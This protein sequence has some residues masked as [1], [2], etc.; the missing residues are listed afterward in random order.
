M[1]Q[2]IPIILTN[3]A[4]RKLIIFLTNLTNNN[5][6][7]PWKLGPGAGKDGGLLDH[8]S[9]TSLA[10]PLINLAD[11]NISPSLDKQLVLELEVR[12]VGLELIDWFPSCVGLCHVRPVNEHVPNSSA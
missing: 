12:E 2:L 5:S 6:K 9:T 11:H 4:I 3:S 1:F 7:Y 10:T 8:H